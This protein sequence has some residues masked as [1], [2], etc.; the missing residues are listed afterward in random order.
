MEPPES[1]VVLISLCLP[2]GRQLRLGLQKIELFIQFL[3]SAL[4]LGKLL[5]LNKIDFFVQLKHLRLS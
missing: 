1:L 5:T 4:G 3:I 2:A